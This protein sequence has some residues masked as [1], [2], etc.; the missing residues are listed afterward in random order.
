MPPCP[1]WW[2]RVF[3][4]VPVVF[5]GAAVHV[6][7]SPPSPG[8]SASPAPTGGQ[9]SVSHLV[10]ANPTTSA[11]HIYLSANLVNMIMTG[12]GFFK[13]V[14]H[15]FDHVLITLLLLITFGVFQKNYHTK[16]LSN[17]SH[18]DHPPIGWSRNLKGDQWNKIVL[19]VQD[20]CSLIWKFTIIVIMWLK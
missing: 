8:A 13:S 6:W 18:F 10:G 5:L 2:V 9:W 19:F 15:L 12:P 16:I 14:E 11:T 3:Y 1:A 17:W 7:L 20:E 4:S